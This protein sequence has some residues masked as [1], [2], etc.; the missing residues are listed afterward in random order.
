[1][2]ILILLLRLFFTNFGFYMTS[3]FRFLLEIPLKISLLIPIKYLII[4]DWMSILFI[5]VVLFIS[6]IVIIY[7]NYY[8]K[9]DPTQRKFI[10]LLSL[11]ITSICLIIISPNVISLILGWDGLGLISYCLVIYYNNIRS[12]ISGLITI[13]RN[14]IGDSALIISILTLFRVGN[15]DWYFIDPKNDYNLFFYFLFLA[16]ITKSAQIPFSAWLPSAIA[17]PTP[18]SALVHSSTLVT[19]GV[20]IFI[21]FSPEI[22]FSISF[23]LIFLAIIT[24]FISGLNAIYEIDFKKIIALSTLSQLGVIISILFFGSPLIAFFHL[25]TH[26][27]FKRLLFLSA[28][29]VLHCYQ[30]NQDLRHIGG[31]TQ[32]SPIVSISII[33]A[34]ISLRGFPFLRGF[35]SKDIILDIFILN[36]LNIILLGIFRACTLFTPIYRIKLLNFSLNGPFNNK[37]IFHENYQVSLSVRLLLVASLLGGSIILWLIVPLEFIVLSLNEKLF[38]F[39][40]LPIAFILINFSAPI[41][42][43]IFL[44]NFFRSILIISHTSLYTSPLTFIIVSK[45]ITLRIDQAWSETLGP[46]KIYSYLNWV[47]RLIEKW[48]YLNLPQIIIISL[49]MLVI[50]LA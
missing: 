5:G 10:T 49:F 3:Q 47:K 7:R 26:A 8:I 9:E 50:T 35:Y 12:N 21:R 25:R 16:G 42:K 36:N 27:L 14:R 34:R 40:S 19:A 6:S 22:R 4:I 48:H 39:S 44:K 30:G 37:I 17:A 2:S 29:V 23:L 24:S 41:V 43:K 46:Q 32:S 28:G 20:Y 18:V 31:Y 45:K 13:L 38:I 33:T 11:F 15:L 1:M